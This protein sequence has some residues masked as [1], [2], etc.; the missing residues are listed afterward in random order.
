MSWRTCK[1]V[2]DEF[3]PGGALK[4]VLLALADYADDAG[5]NIYPSLHSLAV[6]I[7]Y[8]DDQTRRYVRELVRIGAIECVANAQGGKPGSTRHYRIF[9]DRLTACS[10]ATRRG[11]KH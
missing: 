11:G 7:G 4:L 8:S 3:S 5:E 6:K 1:R 10:A 2:W 9:L